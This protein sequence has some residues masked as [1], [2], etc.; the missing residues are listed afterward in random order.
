MI[1]SGFSDLR[2]VIIEEGALPSLVCLTIRDCAHLAHVPN[3][4][5]HLT[6]LNELDLII[7]ASDNFMERIRREGGADWDRVKHI[8]LIRNWHGDDGD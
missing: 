2:Q 7:N 4:I 3:G 8:R 1:I 5:E 6:S